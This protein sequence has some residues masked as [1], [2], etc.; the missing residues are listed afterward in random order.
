[1]S[2]IFENAS[3]LSYSLS[4]NYLN[5]GHLFSSRTKNLKLNGF[6][7]T[8][9]S[10]PDLE[11]VKETFSGINEILSRNTG[12]YEE[13]IINNYSLG[14]GR[15]LDVSFTNENPIFL[16]NYTYTIEIYE[17]GNFNILPS[18]NI[19]GQELQNITDKILNITENLDFNNKSDGKYSYEHSLN[20]QYYNT[21]EDLITK[22]KLLANKIFNDVTVYLGLFGKFSGLYNGLIFKRNTIQENFNLINK[23]ATFIKRMDIDENYKLN[24]SLSLNHSMSLDE[25]GA[26]ILKENGKIFG[27]QQ[28]EEY[29]AKQYLDTELNSAFNRC[30]N[31][32]L[33]Y[34]NENLNP[35]RAN[36]GVTYEKY[37]NIV[38]YDISFSNKLN[39]F[40]GIVH[41][42]EINLEKTN[43]NIF[44][45]TNNGSIKINDKEIGKINFNSPT[46]NILKNI[47]NDAKNMYSDYKFLDTSISFNLVS[48]TNNL[49]LSYN[50]ELNYSIRKTSD[51][52]I[53]KDDNFF[54]TLEIFNNSDIPNKNIYK[55]YIIANKK[56]ENFYF[57]FGKGYEQTPL[58][59][60]TFS[61]K[62]ILLR[63]PSFYYTTGS[64]D[65]GQY[66]V[67]SNT[68]A[69][70]HNKFLKTNNYQN[71]MSSVIYFSG[72][73]LPLN[74][75][76]LGIKN[77]KI[78]SN[79]YINYY[80]DKIKQN[81][82]N[83]INNIGQ[84]YVIDGANLNY[85]SSLSYG[86]DINISS[87]KQIT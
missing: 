62:G 86:A 7:Y 25:N 50:Q 46:E 23:N 39:N 2:Y 13:I 63:L 52:I 14:S 87:L 51:P 55:E 71:A 81:A 4:N 56:D 49:P 67:G 64:W 70:R 26:L 77:K 9:A 80:I 61:L 21:E 10:N 18:D 45:Y 12:Q 16:E 35:N 84:E 41:E 47:Y 66:D 6:L 15:I 1:M 83:N 58:T 68:A 11:G 36:L 20:I 76:K 73:N 27:L 22:S 54:K 85:D 5:D 34:Y 40:S 3:V 82:L 72:S 65:S 28:G 33:S 53:L 43:N 75:F 29:T 74:S 59:K 17:S 30:N 31:L 8:R 24:Y 60:D 32:S 79:N 57:S 42:Y 19:H 69:N 48:G 44:Y 38:S 78:W 37:N